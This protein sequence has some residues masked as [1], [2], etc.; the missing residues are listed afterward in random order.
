MGNIVTYTDANGTVTYTYDDL[1]QL[2]SASNV[3]SYSYDDAGNILSKKEYAYTTDTLGSELSTVNYTYGDSAWG[4]LLTEY[5][6]RTITHD[7]IGN[8]LS[9]GVWTYTWEHGRELAAMSNG[10]TTWTN[11][12]NADGLRTQRTNGTTTYSYVYNG[13]SLSQTTVGS[14]IL[15]FAYD[16]SGTPMSVTYNGT[17]YYYATN[18]QGDVTAILNTSG[19]AVVTYTYDAWGNILTTTGTMAE[20]LGAVNPLR[21]RGYVYDTE[22]QFYYLQSR[23][24]DPEIGRFINADALVSTGQGILGNNMFAYCLN[25]PTN[26]ADPTGTF[27]WW[28]I[29]PVI[30]GLV[31]LLTGCEDNSESYGAAEEYEYSD[32]TKYNCYAHALGLYEWKYVGGSPDAVKD[33]SVENVATM[34]EADILAM[35]W[36]IRHLESYDSPIGKDE[37]RIALST[38][39]DDYH[40]MV[41]HSDGTWS[42]K[43]GFGPTRQINGDNPSCVSWDAPIVDGLLLS[44][45][46]YCE[47]GAHEGYY[48]DGPVYFAVSKGG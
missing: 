19:T 12:Y 38:G 5:G 10:N 2:L 40:F 20:T 39:P 18:L 36:S 17:N 48:N 35:G 31:P 7:E 43:P 11:T 29:V 44:M 8:P 22:T 26:Y 23:Y 42:H 27:G 14:H 46:I 25:N 28:I 47:V 13:S 34:V 6:G 33:F 15:Y 37:F 41:Q 16:V 30:I 24:Y 21:Y 45:G 9:D 32:S 1:G 4:D 3:H